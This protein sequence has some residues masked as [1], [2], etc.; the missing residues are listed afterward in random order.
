MGLVS[1]SPCYASGVHSGPY[2]QSQPLLSQAIRTL[3]NANSAGDKALLEGDVGSI[4][5]VGDD[6]GN[7]CESN[8]VFGCW[9]RRCVEKWSYFCTNQSFWMGTCVS[10]YANMGVWVYVWVVWGGL[11]LSQ[12]T[13]SE[14]DAE[15]SWIGWFCSRKGH[16]FLCEV[17]V[18]TCACSRVSL[19]YVCLKEVSTSLCA[20]RLR[21]LVVCVGVV[22]G[23]RGRY[24]EGERHSVCVC[25]Y[26]L[27][28]TH[29]N[30]FATSRTCGL[31]CCIC[32]ICCAGA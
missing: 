32:C 27:S 28:H 26:Y 31:I 22:V 20:R 11:I 18:C 16:E 25:V 30:T 5:T 4:W 13:T 29:A 10:A 7:S 6:A 21:C 9:R 1:S 14:D 8:F 2:C 23:A 3:F 17:C 15:Y 24:L 19:C 12:Y